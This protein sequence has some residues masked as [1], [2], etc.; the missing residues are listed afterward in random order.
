MLTKQIGGMKSVT[1]STGI[2]LIAATLK[3]SWPDKSSWL[4]QEQCAYSNGS[5]F[6]DVPVNYDYLKAN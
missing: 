2:G 1:G 3:L 4:L 5:L 6:M